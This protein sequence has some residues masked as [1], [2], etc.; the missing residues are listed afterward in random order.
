MDQ[1]LRTEP[2]TVEQLQQKYSLSISK[3]ADILDQF[4]GDRA[5]IDKMLK[6]CHQKHVD[7]H[8]KSDTDGSC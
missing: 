6:R 8:P 5:L 1:S 4:K 2:Y 3:A 7:G